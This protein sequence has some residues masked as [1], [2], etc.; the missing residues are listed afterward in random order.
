MQNESTSRTKNSIVNII[1]SFGG[2]LVDLVARFLLRTV[3]IY[4]LGK[5]YLGLSGLFGNILS[6]LSLAD[7]GI[8]VAIT[9][10][11]YRP[12]EENDEA[13]IKVLMR[14][15]KKTYILVG[16]FVLI[17]GT[18]L[19]PFL[20]V[21]IKDMPENIP[22]I[23]LIYVLFVINAAISYFYSYKSSYIIANQKN[24]IVTNNRYLMNLLCA[25]VQSVVLFVYGNYIAFL[26]VQIA[27]TMIQNI[28]ISRKADKMYPFLK[29]PTDEKL[30][31]ETKTTIVANVKALIIQRVSSVIVF[32]TD[33]LLLSKIF[34]LVIVGLYSNYTLVINALEAILNQFFS[35]ITASI[36]NLGV[37]A[38]KEH[39]E[40]IFFVTYFVDFW[41][42]SFS[43]IALGTLF[44]PFIN[45]WVGDSYLMTTGCVCFIVM[46]FYLKGM[47]QAV[48][49]FNNAFGMMQYFRY[50]PVWECIINI[51]ASIGLALIFGPVGIFIGTTISTLA[52]PFWFEPIILFKHGLDANSA[53]FFGKFAGY[54]IFTA[55]VMA[56]MLFL[57]NLISVGGL[58]G[59]ILKVLITGIVPNALIILVFFKSRE[60]GYLKGVA[61][62]VVKRG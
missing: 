51:G 26:I 11:L 58:V 13:K 25:I 16:S 57:T 46:N 5:E 18:S 31:D 40:E 10:S 32:S 52:V 4:T 37:N 62:R 1:F 60:F 43:A 44:Q 24:Y 6:I 56:L 20:E 17:V 19:T 35:A 49:T 2:Q 45:I 8:G 33:N 29:V 30:D 53:K 54:T 61:A 59:F 39:Q 48:V 21:F 12:I 14:V 41:M 15:F 3:F 23:R 36:G 55:A 34:G 27:F 38:D 50:V 22:N 42:Y 47:R 28:V 9:F 7:L